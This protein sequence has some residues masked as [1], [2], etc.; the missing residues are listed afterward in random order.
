MPS[1]QA[2]V[3]SHDDP[4]PKLDHASNLILI[5]NYDSFTYNVSQYLVLEGATVQVVRNDQ[6]TLDDLINRNPTQLVI[7]PGPGHP[8]TDSGVSSEA[9]KHFTGKIPILGVCMGQQCMYTTFGGTVASANEILHGKTS[10]ILHDR[11]GVYKDVDQSIPVTRYHSL[12]GTYETL[13]SCLEVT[14]WTGD[15]GVIM[16]VRHKEFVVEG[17]QYHPE[18]ILTLAGRQLFR[19]FLKWKGG[20]WSD[21]DPTLI[22]DVGHSIA[23]QEWRRTHQ[24][25]ISAKPS[26]PSI[27]DKIYADRKRKVAIQKQIPGQRPEDLLQISEMQLAPPLIDFPQRLRNSPYP[28]AL[29]AEVKRASPSK[30]II[31]INTNAAVQARRYALSGAA[32]ISVLTEPE[33]F[34]GSL[35]DMRNARAAVDGLTNRPAIL[36][37]EFIF[38]EYQILE[39]RLA[40]ADTVLLIVKMLSDD[41]LERLYK[42]SLSLSMEPLVEVSSAEEMTKA[43]KLNA[44][45]IGVNN[46]DLHSFNVDLG[47]TSSLVSMV[48]KDTILIAL[49]GISERK[50]VERYE[51]DGAHAVLVGESLMRAGEKPKPFIEK[52][53]SSGSSGAPEIPQKKLLVKICGTRTTEAAKI[54]AEHG[55]DLVGVILVEGSKRCIDLA[56]ASQISETLRITEKGGA[57]S[58]AQEVDSG[59]TITEDF[60]KHHLRNTLSHPRRTL[61]VGVFQN[62]PLSYILQAIRIASLDVVQLHG[63]EPIEWAKLIPVPVVHVFKPGEAGLG[64]RGYHVAPLLDAGSGGSGS[65]LDISEVQATLDSGV[66]AM[67]AGGLSPDNVKDLINRLGGLESNLGGVDVSS[68]V[69][70]NGEKDPEKIKRFIAEARSDLSLLGSC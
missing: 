33:W 19:N 29:L 52:L 69:E 39:A 28:L 9:I 63:Q 35:E 16:G 20:K 2:T 24:T 66:P 48:P 61:L 42:Y 58:T 23:Y 21:N 67:L 45:V 43:L 4:Q 12:A 54:A 49:S 25:A 14:S 7:S 55:A 34:K 11:I 18:S 62:Q 56:T 38:D 32:A 5:D 53:M 47:T 50:D 40:G 68:G 10:D 30:G 1:F 51:R 31:D 27:L 65:S 17:V 13:P 22:G 6:I 36:R 60:F 59:E 15:R 41:L 70:T 26:E 8:L 64:T 57:S 46:R 44:K 3:L 37:K